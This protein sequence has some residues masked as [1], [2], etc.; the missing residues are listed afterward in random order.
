MAKEINRDREPSPVSDKNHQTQ[1]CQIMI[2]YNTN[3]PVEPAWNR[4]VHSM[5]IEWEAHN[6]GYSARLV[7]GIFKENAAERLRHVD[8]DNAAEGLEY[9]DFLGL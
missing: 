9:W 1:I 4:T 5:L 2:G 7:I 3:N 8:F 6:D